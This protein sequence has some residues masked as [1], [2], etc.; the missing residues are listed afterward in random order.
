MKRLLLISNYFYP[1]IGGIE[2]VARDLASAVRE[3]PDFEVKVLCFNETARDG[4]VV[5]RRG[6]TVHDTVDGTEIIRCGCVTKKASQSISLTFGTELKKLMEGYRPDIVLFE[7]P[8]PFQ[9]AFLEKYLRQAPHP[10]RFLL[11]WQ[12]DITKQKA[13]GKLF[14]AQTERLLQRADQIIATTPIY[15]EG[16]PFLSRYREKCVVIPNCIDTNRLTVTDEI[17]KKAEAFRKACEGKIL[18]FGVGR[19]IPYKGFTNLVKAS[20]HLDDRFRI[21]IG[22]SGPLTDELK[23]EAK[24]DDKITFLGR[25]SN[26]DLIA[27]DL[28]MD[29]F[30]FPSITK[31]EAF[32]LALAEGMYFGKP[33]VTFH[34]PGSGVNYLNEKDVTGLEVPNG[35]AKAYAEALTRLADSPELRRQMG[36]AA[37]KRVESL[38]L[39]ESFRKSFQQLFRSEEPSKNTGSK[40][41]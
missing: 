19:H 40:G 36:E 22:G 5:C 34:I 2:Q 31:N 25:I 18:C 20:R 21:L 12:L 35:D 37:R 23:A 30:C 16:S 39:P 4:D 29:I 13:L 28:A 15:V 17:R 24:G 27:Y 3:M 6:E 26:E 9:A 14:N 11:H 8:N 7:Y 38:F 41:D 32:G 10:F 33:A 1:N